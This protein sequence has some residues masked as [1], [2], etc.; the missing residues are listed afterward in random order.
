MN[1]L[2][3]IT[4]ISLW[5]MVLIGAI[6]NLS[7]VIGVITMVYGTYNYTYWCLKTNKHTWGGP[8]NAVSID[9]RLAT[10]SASE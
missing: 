10:S 7:I 5:F 3:N 9:G 6:T 4:P 2:V 1:E 8:G